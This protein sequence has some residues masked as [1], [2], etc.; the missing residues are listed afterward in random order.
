MIL[1]LFEQTLIDMDFN[2]QDIACF[3]VDLKNVVKHERMKFINFFMLM[4]LK[5]KLKENIVTVTKAS[6][7]FDIV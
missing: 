2:Y 1:N 4:D 3:G 6:Q 5:R 7:V